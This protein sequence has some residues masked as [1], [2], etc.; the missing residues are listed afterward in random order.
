[1]IDG[2]DGRGRRGVTD[3]SFIF[4]SDLYRSTAF[5]ANN[6]TTIPAAM[7]YHFGVTRWKRHNLTPDAGTRLSRDLVITR[8]ILVTLE[9]NYT[10]C[11]GR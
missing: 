9:W 4:E 2:K 1:M 3:V 11:Q 5:L 7:Q 6:Q 10:F 8:R